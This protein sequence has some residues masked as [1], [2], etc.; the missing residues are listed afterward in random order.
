MAPEFPNLVRALG[1][2]LWPGH[3]GVHAERVDQ[4]LQHGLDAIGAHL[5]PNEALPEVGR[6]RGGDPQTSHDAGRS[7]ATSKVHAAVLDAY[8]RMGPMTDEA[9]IVWVFRMGHKASDSSVRSRRA[10]LVAAGKVR[11][12]GQRATTTSGR[13]AIVWERVPSPAP[14]EANDG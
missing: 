3:N 12:S 9:L 8:D 14:G 1:H 11:D 4:M 5:T 10:E 6:A 13:K 7:V 2:A